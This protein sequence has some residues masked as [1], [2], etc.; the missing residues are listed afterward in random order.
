MNE[1]RSRSVAVAALLAASIIG[2]GMGR[3]ASAETMKMGYVDVRSA[4]NESE[5]GKK[6]KAELEAIIKTKQGAID[7]KGK[8][9]EKLKADLDK[10][11]SVLSSEAKKAKEDEIERMMREYQRMAQDAQ[12][13]LKKKES[14][15]TVAILKELKEVIDKMGQEEGYS[16]IFENTDGIILYAKKEIDLTDKVVKRYNESAAAKQKGTK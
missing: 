4:L 1:K 9:I 5:P 12:T 3:P 15:F 2:W 14:E 11:A 16:V 10:Q 6:A 7:E 13:E 8:A